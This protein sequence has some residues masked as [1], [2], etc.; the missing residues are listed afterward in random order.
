M[1]SPFTNLWPVFRGPLRILLCGAAASLALA[2]VR[3]AGLPPL[4]DLLPPFSS[5]PAQTAAL[6]V[7]LV[8]VA[9]AAF[10]WWLAARSFAFLRDPR[11]TPEQLANLRDLP[12]ALPEG[13]VRALLALIVGVVGLPLLLF[14]QALALTDATAGYV[15]GIIAGVFGY[16]FGARS[17][18]GGD[19]AARRLGE[20]MAGQGKQAEAL[21]QENGA[22]RE[23][24][25]A[26]AAAAAGAQTGQLAAALDALGRQIAIAGNLL[27][28]LGPALPAGLVPPG[29]A[30]ALAR[31]GAGRAARPG[32]GRVR[33]CD[34]AG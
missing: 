18:A 7:F 27:D 6:L 19:A 29:A 23:R 3:L 22:L 17:T 33:K 25:D 31:A 5:S 20:A 9:F 15:N 30:D 2:S 26:A 10:L 14:S 1:D 16:Y 34:G 12:L 32:D 8:G 4:S 11:T 13:T 28:V 24:A 21:R